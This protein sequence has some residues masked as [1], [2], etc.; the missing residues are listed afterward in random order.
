[1]VSIPTAPPTASGRLHPKAPT[2]KQRQNTPK[3][4]Q[5]QTFSWP[6]VT[7]WTGIRS[8]LIRATSATANN[9]A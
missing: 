5:D 1:M 3:N 7:Y 4:G 6:A 9:T 2:K 8:R